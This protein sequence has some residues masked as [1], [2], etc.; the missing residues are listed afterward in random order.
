MNAWLITF[1]KLLLLRV[2]QTVYISFREKSKDGNP[3]RPKSLPCQ[4]CEITAS[5]HF[6]RASLVAQLVENPPAMRETWVWSLGWEDPLEKGK[7]TDSS[8]LAWRIPWT[9][10]MGSHIFQHRL[11]FLTVGL[12]VLTFNFLLHLLEGRS[13]LFQSCSQLTFDS[14]L[15]RH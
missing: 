1:I 13:D 4:N 9:I 3:G 14:F 2:Q 5:R 10:L 11:G 7:A 6:Y 15:L 12:S 8:I